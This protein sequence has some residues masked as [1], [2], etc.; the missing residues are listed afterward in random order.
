MNI[1]R[2]CSFDRVDVGMRID[3]HD[4]SIGMVAATDKLIALDA[5]L[6]K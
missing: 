6:N 4:A 3:P 5:I 2:C 1:S